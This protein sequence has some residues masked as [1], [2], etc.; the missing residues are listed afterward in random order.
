MTSLVPN[1]RALRIAGAAVIILFGIWAGARVHVGRVSAPPTALHVPAGEAS[2]PTETDAAAAFDA[3]VGDLANVPERLPD[4]S[5]S[6]LTGSALPIARFAGKSLVLNFWATWC[7]P[8]RREIP[9]LKS[10]YAEWRGRNIEV[11]GI[12]VDYREKVVAYAGELKIAYPLMVGE[13]DALAVAAKFGVA[14]PV[15]PFTVF[16]DRRGNVV[17]LYVGELHKPQADLI[18]SVVQNLDADRLPLA[19]ARHR[20]AVGLHA[21][22]PERTG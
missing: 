2:L 17:T 5:L 7:A 18:L 8:C 9:L 20:I 6:D 16:T 10:L 15:F 19:E 12:A 3:A 1:G 11:V 21:L 22:A 14:S 4:F 13:E